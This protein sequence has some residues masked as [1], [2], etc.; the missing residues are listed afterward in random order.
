MKKTLLFLLLL[1]L[2]TCSD[3]KSASGVDFRPLSY[4]EAYQTADTEQKMLLVY[5]YSDT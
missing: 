5:V 1:L 2:T 3:H 4:E